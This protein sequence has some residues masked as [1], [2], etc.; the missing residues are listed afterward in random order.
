MRKI[1]F[2][3]AVVAVLAMVGAPLPA[4]GTTNSLKAR[5]VI[6][7]EQT[8]GFVGP[9]FKSARLP[10]VV[11]YSDGRV[12]SIHNVNGSVKEMFEGYINAAGIGAQVA[13]FVNAAQT[14]L[15]GWGTPTVTDVP[16]TDVLVFHNGRKSV[17]HVYALGFESNKMSPAAIAARSQ[18][19]KTIAALVKLSGRITL[20]KPMTYEVWPLWIGPP[21]LGIGAKI[22]KPAAIL[23]L[24]QNGTLV[25]GM[26]KLDSPTPSPDL[27]I[28]YC[29]LADGS[30]VEEW[31]YFYQMSKTGIL[32]PSNIA[33]P[34]DVCVRVVAKSMTSR[35][36]AAG[37][38]KWLLPSGALINLTWR[39]VLPAEI[40]C[41]R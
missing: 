21:Q 3:A 25:A 22:M 8:G 9:N 40:A 28:E 5:V 26:V 2:T 30:F 24:S 29:R 11:L 41:K 36:R 35:L 18:L 33:A 10:E 19:I 38:K 32:W 17:A 14:P 31:A 13:F 34:N 1:V 20:Y 4:N 37:S 23:C 27:S 12:L 15:G 39:P 7:V 16:T 6:R